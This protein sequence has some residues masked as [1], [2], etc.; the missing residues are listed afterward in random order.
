VRRPPVRPVEF[1]LLEQHRHVLVGYRL[2]D[3]PLHHLLEQLAADRI[4]FGAAAVAVI[5]DHL[6]RHGPGRRLVRLGHVALHFVQKETRGFQRT[7]DQG[8]IARHVDQR[9]HQRR[10]ADVD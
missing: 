5:G 3:E 9:Q 6:E 2:A 4:G 10:D 8:G 7:A 1:H